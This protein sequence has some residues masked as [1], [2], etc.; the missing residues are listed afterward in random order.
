MTQL[1]KLRIEEAAQPAPEKPA[2]EEPAPAPAP[3][4]PATGAV[5]GPTTE[6]GQEQPGGEL[7]VFIY[8]VRR[9]VPV[10]KSIMV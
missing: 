9:L 4:T 7:R 8:I 3:P 10:M 2:P 6:A 1:V 5:P